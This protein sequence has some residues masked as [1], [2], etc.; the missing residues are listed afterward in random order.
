[1]RVLVTEQGDLLALLEDGPLRREDLH[2]LP[3]AD[4]GEAAEA[5][6]REGV[7]LLVLP[8]DADPDFL[9]SL[10]REGIAVS[11]AAGARD[12]HEALEGAGVS[13]RQDARVP[14]HVSVRIE[15][16][17]EVVRGLTRDVSLTGAFVG[18]SPR[19]PP[20]TPVVLSLGRGMRELRLDARVVRTVEEG[21]YHLPGVGL[22][23]DELSEDQ[24]RTLRALLEGPLP[25]RR[26][27][28]IRY[29]T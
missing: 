6:V 26:I 10:R 14:L 16:E 27:P 9:Q 12:V 13:P 17:E 2:L 28:R 3:E 21:D 1:M 20:G 24:R 8:G 22:A 15:R 18:C 5:A 29:R 19:L 11:A 7:D 25:V 4:A 23:F